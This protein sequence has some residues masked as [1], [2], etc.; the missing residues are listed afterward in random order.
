MAPAAQPT[1]KPKVLVATTCR[2]YPTARLAMALAEAGCAVEALC[3]AGHALGKTGAVERTYVY[4]GLAPLRS[5]ETAITAAKPE[6]IVPGDDL[7]TWHLHELHRQLSRRR[8][9]LSGKAPAESDTFCWLIEDSLGAPESFPV[10]QSRSAF[11]EAARAEGVLVPDFEVIGDLQDLRSWASRA[12]LPTVLKADGTS[13]GDG[14]K[15]VRTLGDAEL[16]WRKLQAPP[17]WARAAKR[18]LADRDRTLVWPAL[19]RR[20]ATVSAQAFIPGCEATSTIACW[21]GSVLASL[22]FEVIRKTSSAGHA[23]VV[24]QI[25]NQEMSRAVA[26]MARRLKLSGLYG[27]DFMLESASGRAYLIEINPRSTQV[28]HLRLG[29]GQDLPAALYAALSGCAPRPKERICQNGTIA[30]FPQEWIRDPASPFL[31]SAHH[32][33]PWEAPELVRDCVN[34]RRK[35]SAWYSRSAQAATIEN[36]AEPEKSVPDEKDRDRDRD[37]DSDG[38]DAPRP[39]YEPAILQ[40]NRSR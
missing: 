20:R 37:R 18:A 16:A 8:E 5:L 10:V 33:V 17:L 21:K 14:V 32:D 22:H 1:V 9:N 4:R 34:R 36:A 24:R 35:Q 26:T 7:A 31:Q 25:E 2:W 12:G 15:V 40:S 3:P 29:V 19:K 28:A 38:S 11:M 13:G 30:L 6:M 27:F 23:T 39:L